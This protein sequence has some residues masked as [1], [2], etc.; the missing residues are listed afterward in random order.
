MRQM[1][2][3]KKEDYETDTGKTLNMTETEFIDLTR[4]NL[5]ANVLDTV[6]LLTMSMML[7][8][9][10]ANE[11]DEDEDPRIRNSYKFAIKAAD[12]LRDELLYFYDPTSVV[13]LIS[14]GF[15]PSISLLENFAT[16]LK[17]FGKETFALYEGD[18]A[19]AKKNYVIKYLLKSF[20]ITSQA[21][22]LLPMFYPDLAKDLGMKPQSQY[23]FFK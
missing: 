3:K 8:G 16:L 7:W 18:E 9:L 6:F 15:F 19:A 4:K 21:S 14:K 11:P 13:G 12:K 2:E 22:S 1:Y 20:P 17:N 23:G 10:K 5:K